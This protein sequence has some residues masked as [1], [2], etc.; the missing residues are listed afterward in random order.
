[1]RAPGGQ[2]L[3]QRA[4]HRQHLVVQHAPGQ[5]RLEQQRQQRQR[6]KAVQHQHQVLQAGPKPLPKQ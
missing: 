1:L 3:A 2:R 6:H 5:Q 4:L